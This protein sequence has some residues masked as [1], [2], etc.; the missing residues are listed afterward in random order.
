MRHV[1]TIHFFLIYFWAGWFHT[2]SLL[3]WGVY[4][5]GTSQNEI[6]DCNPIMDTGK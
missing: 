1:I 5:H 2:R 6:V 4:K 3:C